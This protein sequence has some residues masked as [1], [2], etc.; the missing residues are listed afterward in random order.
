MKQQLLDFNLEE[1]KKDPSKIVAIKLGDTIQRV[2]I[3][4][5]DAT[6]EHF[7]E[8]PI[9][10]LIDDEDY[11]QP[12]TALYTAEGASSEDSTTLMFIQEIYEPDDIVFANRKLGVVKEVSD[13]TLCYKVKFIGDKSITI[14]NGEELQYANN[15][16]LR[17][18]IIVKCK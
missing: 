5:T 15:K 11:Q 16:D 2:R 6:T 9:V 8:Y 1:F 4:C 18:Y 17:E 13:H 3:I 14:C 10:I 7:S 12:Y